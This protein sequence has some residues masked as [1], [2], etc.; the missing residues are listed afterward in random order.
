MTD[1]IDKGWALHADRVCLLP[2]DGSDAWTYRDVGEMTHR[3]A[4]GLS[5]LGVG[6]GDRVG[7][8]SA[9]HPLAF[10]AMLAV[11]RA[12]AVYVPLNPS[13]TAHE[14]GPLMETTRTRTLLYDPALISKM[15]SLRAAVPH[16]VLT[17]RLHPGAT[18]H[19]DRV[20]DEILAPPGT[21]APEPSAGSEDPAWMAGTGGTTG[22][23]KAVVIPHRALMTQTYGFLAHLPEAHPIQLAAAP[24]THAAGALTLPVLMQGGTT[25]IHRGVDV[26][27]IMADIERYQITRLFLPPTAIY[28]MLAHPELEQHDFSSLKYFLYGAAPMSAEKLTEARRAFG[29]VMTQFFG[30]SEV[31][32]LCT[33]MSPQ[34]HEEAFEDPAKAGRLASAGRESLVARVAILDRDGHRLPPGEVGEI[35]IRSDLRMTGYLDAPGETASVDRGNGWHGTS[36]LGRMDEDGFVYIVDRARDMIITGGFNVYPSEVE[37]VLLSMPQVRD[38]AVIGVPHDHWG[39]AVTAFV[40]PVERA[41]VDPDALVA[42]CKE[43]LGSVKAPKR[44]IVRELPKSPVGKVL[45]KELRAEYWAGRVRQV[46]GA[47]E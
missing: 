42:A 13:S 47:V 5:R 4:V 31:P 7:V 16:E 41:D 34:D 30:Q 1:T 43:V 45:K 8:L 28:S 33:L 27:T 19:P 12:D 15:E 6:H 3:I 10:I 18:D 32:M 26:A 44:V 25:V 37:R 39:E 14:L 17:I 36:D 21:R 9:N 11:L 46:G 23:P 2:A 24:L 29:P 35:A 22:Q 20:L 38:C 40:E